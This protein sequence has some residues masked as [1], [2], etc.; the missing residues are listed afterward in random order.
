MAAQILGHRG[1]D[2]SFKKGRLVLARRGRMNGDH[3][4]E[5]PRLR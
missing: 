5:K 3:H 4:G 1:L 2:S